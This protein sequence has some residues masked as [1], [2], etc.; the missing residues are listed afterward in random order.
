MSII[1]ER[2][3]VELGQAEALDSTPRCEVSNCF[4]RRPPRW[5]SAVATHVARLA[6]G[7]SRRM[8]LDLAVAHIR[9]MRKK[10]RLDCSLCGHEFGKVRLGDIMR[11]DP[12]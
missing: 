10:S 1:D 11:V 9:E 8:C 6:C 4:C 12:L 7:C 3:T 2:R 5:E